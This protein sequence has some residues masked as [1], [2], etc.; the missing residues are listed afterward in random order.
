MTALRICSIANCSNA[1]YQR[2]MCGMHYHRWYR[3]VPLEGPKKVTLEETDAFILAALASQT[4]ECIEWPWALSNGY[5]VRDPSKRSVVPFKGKS[6]HREICR[7]AHGEPLPEQKHAA[8]NCGN[9]PCINPRHLRWAT[10][11]ENSADKKIHG[12]HRFG[13]SLPWAK[14]TEADVVEMRRLH[15]EDGLNC[16]AVS[17]VYG[18]D[19]STAWAIITR[20]S[21][22]HVL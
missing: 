10:V 22:T 9:P 15:E 20:K 11:K 1:S 16:K 18:L 12:T 2:K 4:D 19:H 5:G 8:H 6:V 13:S 21:W 7:I 14:V 3:G 17:K